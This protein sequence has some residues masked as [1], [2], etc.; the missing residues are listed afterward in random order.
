LRFESSSSRPAGVFDAAAFLLAGGASVIVTFTSL[1]V[2]SGPSLNA[3]RDAG[4]A[5]L[6]HFSITTEA[7]LAFVLPVTEEASALV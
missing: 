4:Q 7:E 3:F 2:I 6:S 1:D 5:G